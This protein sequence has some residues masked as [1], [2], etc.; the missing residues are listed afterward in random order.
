MRI[1]DAERRSSLTF[2][3]V[4]VKSVFSFYRKRLPLGSLFLILDTC[5]VLYRRHSDDHTELSEEVFAVEVA[6]FFGYLND[7]QSRSREV[8]FRLGDT[9]DDAVLVE[10][11]AEALLEHASEVARAAGEKVVEAFAVEGL[12]RAGVYIGTYLRHFP[13]MADYALLV[14]RLCLYICFCL[15]YFDCRLVFL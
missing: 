10:T 6:A 3:R 7:V 11:D 4:S 5:A 14:E 15:L 1:A 12:G 9:G 8:I 13:V 2:E